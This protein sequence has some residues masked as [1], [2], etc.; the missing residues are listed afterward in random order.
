MDELAIICQ[1]SEAV[2]QKSNSNV[3]KEMLAS[4]DN[5]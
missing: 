4:V 5:A 2:L 1:D 3:K